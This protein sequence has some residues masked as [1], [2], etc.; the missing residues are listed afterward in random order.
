MQRSRAMLTA[1]P[2][3]LSPHEKPRAVPHALLLPP[4]PPPRAH[5]CARTPS[6]ASTTCITP[7]G[8]VS[9]EREK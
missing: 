3:W 1:E 9:S 6:I 7:L 2:L 5:R 4:P 8:Y